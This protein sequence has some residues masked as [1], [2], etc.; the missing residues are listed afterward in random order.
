MFCAGPC[1][2][3][4]VK[5]LIFFAWDGRT[6]KGYNSG[7]RC[8]GSRGRNTSPLWRVYSWWIQ[9][10]AV[11]E[12]GSVCE[13]TSISI[14]PP[15]IAFT[16]QC[17][18]LIPGVAGHIRQRSGP[19]ASYGY[20][21]VI[22]TTRPFIS[23]QRPVMPQSHPEGCAAGACGDTGCCCMTGCLAGAFS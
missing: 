23:P 15:S 11:F 10:R 6:G 7:S 20:D 22:G 9:L 18:E 4:Y 12:E 21:A 2:P 14:T 3:E 1:I 19:V 16:R 17:S 8:R 13:P 5:R